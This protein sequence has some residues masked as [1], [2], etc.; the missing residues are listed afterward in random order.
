MSGD[1]PDGGFQTSCVCG[2]RYSPRRNREERTLGNTWELRGSELEVRS[3]EGCCKTDP[4][5]ANGTNT[6]LYSYGMWRSAT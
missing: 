6:A 1:D 4:V 2:T 5:G 3:R